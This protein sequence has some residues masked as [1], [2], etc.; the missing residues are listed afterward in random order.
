[1]GSLALVSFGRG[2]ILIRS[3]K[4]VA[5]GVGAISLSAN[6]SAA[7]LYYPTSRGVQ[8]ITGLPDAPQSSSMTTFPALSQSATAMAVSDDG[9]VVLMVTSGS[10]NGALFLL[11]RD[12]QSRVLT[13]LGKAS[14]VSFVPGTRNA[15]VADEQNDTILLLQDVTGAATISSLAGAS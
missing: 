5:G 8:F 4:G 3:I 12:S 15:L 7:A 11:T 1:D 10:Q 13:L 6:G 14:A 2:S 9:E